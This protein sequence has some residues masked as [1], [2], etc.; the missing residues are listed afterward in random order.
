[1][2]AVLEGLALVGFLAAVWILRRYAHGRHGSRTARRVS[3]LALGA[4]VAF[5][6]FVVVDFRA[7]ADNPTGA[8]RNVALVATVVAAILGYRWLLQRARDAADRR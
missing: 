4:W 1:M 8:L 2:F 5:A 3:D 7:L 6:L